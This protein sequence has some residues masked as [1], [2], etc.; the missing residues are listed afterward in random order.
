MEKLELKIPPIIQV[1]VI[2][3]LMI[4]SSAYLPA[5]GVSIWA[6]T[7]LALVVFI[8]GMYFSLAGVFEFR[9][10][11][12]TVDPR[13]PGNVSALVDSGIYQIS[14][15]PMYVGFAL[16]LFSI[17]I[18][19]CSPLLLLGVFAFVLFM[20]RFQ[21]SPEEAYLSNAFGEEYESYKQKV[22][23]WV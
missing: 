17:V 16:F 15:N 5:I 14:R 11:R 1:I 21:I 10:K 2:G 6:R 23:R 19:F 3:I 9:R 8:V 4:V 22:R 18:F 13:Y 20:N 12:T 7:Y